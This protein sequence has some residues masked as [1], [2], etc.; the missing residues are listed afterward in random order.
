MARRLWIRGAL[1]AFILLLQG[2]PAAAAFAPSEHHGEVFDV[3]KESVTRTFELTDEIHAEVKRW[4]ASITGPAPLVRADPDNGI[5]L[6]IPLRPPIQVERPDFHASANEVFVFVPKDQK[7]YL[8]IFSEQNEPR[9]F[10]FD[11]PVEPF[12]RKHKFLK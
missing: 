10:A 7:P 4:L 12:L 11:S 2:F 8:L 3:K 1:L 5:V 6:H 9:I